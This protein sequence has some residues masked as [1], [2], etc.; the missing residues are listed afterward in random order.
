M[1]D[2]IT[3]PR[4]DAV[5]KIRAA[6]GATLYYQRRGGQLHQVPTSVGAVVQ[7]FLGSSSM[8]LKVRLSDSQHDVRAVHNRDERRGY[9]LEYT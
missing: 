9:L 1:S 6:I 4:K 3:I 2:L 7:A 8:R 5:H